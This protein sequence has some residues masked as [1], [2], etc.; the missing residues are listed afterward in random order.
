MQPWNLKYIPTMQLDM[1]LAGI[2]KTAN[3][4]VSFITLSTDW[5][6]TQER[7]IGKLTWILASA[8]GLRLFPLYVL[9]YNWCLN[10]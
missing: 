8:V 7:K 4:E 9:R 3:P 10:Y 6:Y 2:S 5:L 1:L